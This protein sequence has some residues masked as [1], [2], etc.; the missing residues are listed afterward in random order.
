MCAVGKQFSK[1][2]ARYRP[3]SELIIRNQLKSIIATKSKDKNQVK[4]HTPQK[5]HLHPLRD[6]CVQY[7]NNPG[8]ALRDIVRK[9]NLLAAIN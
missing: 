7:E 5:A 1:R 3:K 9:L 8:N 4:G 2:F 6:L